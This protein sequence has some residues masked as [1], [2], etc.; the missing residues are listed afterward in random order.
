MSV[1]VMAGVHFMA[2]TTKL[3]NP[4]KIVLI[5]DMKAGCSLAE[6]ITGADVRRHGQLRQRRPARA[7]ADDEGVFD[8]R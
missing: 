1:I 5:P 4:K 2:E 8:E 3:M 6:S 7:R